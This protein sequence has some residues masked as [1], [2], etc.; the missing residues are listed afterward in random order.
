MKRKKLDVDSETALAVIEEERSMEDSGRRQKEERERMIAECHEV[1][2]QIKGVQMLVKFG[3]VANLVWLKEVKESKIYRDVPS[4]GTWDK[5]CECIGKSRRQIDEDL[6]NLQVFGDEFLGYV[7]GLRVGYRELKKL[8]QLTFDGAVIIDAKSVQIGGER[9]P[10]DLEH[11]EDLQVAIERLLDEKEK[12]LEDAQITIRTRDK[13]LSSKRELIKK[14]EKA[15]SKLE[16]EA[17]AKGLTLD[18]DAFITK[19][20]SLKISFDGYLQRLDPTVAFNKYEEVTPRMRAALISALH[21]MKMQ[22]FSAYDMA[23]TTHGNPAMNPELLED[24]E[25]WQAENL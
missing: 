21:Y 19:I 4:I 3:D 12:A 1:I 15:L 16:K 18:E 2:G 24:Y 8:R 6:L 22:I 7:A 10:F 5:F 25:R 17:D 9:I 20:E 23:V 13:E 14:Q 11:K